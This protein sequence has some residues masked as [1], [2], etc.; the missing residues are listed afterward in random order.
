MTALALSGFC[1]YTILS[2]FSFSDLCVLLDMDSLHGHGCAL[3]FLLGSG[4]RILL[5]TTTMLES[6]ELVSKNQVYLHDSSTH[7]QQL[8]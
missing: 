5:Y 1:H 3:V 2:N 4:R 6:P 7:Q 8:P